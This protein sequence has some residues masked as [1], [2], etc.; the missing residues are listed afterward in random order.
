MA[1]YHDSTLS[2]FKTAWQIK[3]IA[4]RYILLKVELGGIKALYSRPY[5]AFN[6]FL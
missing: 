5:R 6:V 1:F 4:Y 2:V 3:D